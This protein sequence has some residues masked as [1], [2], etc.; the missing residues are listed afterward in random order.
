[1]I[2]EM[3]TYAEGS[4]IEAQI[5]NLDIPSFLSAYTDA[6]A[7][8]GRYMNEYQSEIIDYIVE[9]ENVV[10]S[11]VD[12]EMKDVNEL[13]K[14]Y[15]HYQ[16]KVDGLRK[17]VNSAQAKGKSVNDA[18]AEK[19]KRNEDKLDEASDEFEEAAAPLCYLF[20]EVVHNAYKDLYPL[21]LTMM[22]WES[23]RSYTES[24]VFG[25]FRS[26]LL[27]AAFHGTTV[28]P[29]SDGAARPQ[30]PTRP[31]SPTR[32]DY[33]PQTP[34]RSSAAAGRNQ[35]AAVAASPRK[36]YEIDDSEYSESS[37]GSAPLSPVQAGRRVD[38]V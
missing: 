1:M 5:K 33:A 22:E 26:D 24:T 13:R 4:P 25:K 20:E 18:T 16:V 9:W 19:L 23:E 7:Q 21:V 32:R 38:Q 27:E 8:S 15:N 30:S 3:C 28:A 35:N 34:T 14:T 37:Y 11:R 31:K 29:S 10:S 2:E 12:K 36:P 6:S 17:K